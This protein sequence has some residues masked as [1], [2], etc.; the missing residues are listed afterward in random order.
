MSPNTPNCDYHSAAAR[1]LD[2]PYHA[3]DAYD[4][5]RTRTLVNAK[6]REAQDNL[7]FLREDPGFFREVI[8]EA[9]TDTN[10]AL[11]RRDFD[12]SYHSL[13]KTARHDAVALALTRLYQQA[14]L[15]ETV[16]RLFDNLIATCESSKGPIEP[17]QLLPTSFMEILSR[18]EYCLD[19]AI[20][21]WIIRL[22]WFMAQTPAFKQYITHS[23][24][25]GGPEGRYQTCLRKHPGKLLND[26]TLP[27]CISSLV[28]YEHHSMSQLMFSS[29]QRMS[30]IGFSAN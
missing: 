21:G 5:R 13:T 11:V 28:R 20:S 17:G 10:E 9:C 19:D 26:F 27:R 1:T 7:L 30:F 15:W 29:L 18:L 22:S 24:V 23:P 16:C 25:P 8:L 3:T 12:P 14:F 2:S 6:N 4:F